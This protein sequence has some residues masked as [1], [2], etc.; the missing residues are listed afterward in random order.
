MK[1][2]NLFPLPP[3]PVKIHCQKCDVVYFH[4]LGLGL[5]EVKK[6]SYRKWY[7]WTCRVCRNEIYEFWEKF[8]PN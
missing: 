2:K 3:T 6:G 8:E 7:V 1:A 5:D 4:D